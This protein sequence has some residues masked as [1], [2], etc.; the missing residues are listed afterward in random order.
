MLPTLLLNVTDWYPSLSS[1]NSVSINLILFFPFQSLFMESGGIIK[2]NQS[3]RFCLLLGIAK[4]AIYKTRKA[5][6]KGKNVNVL[7]CF[8]GMV[9]VRVKMEQAYLLSL[10]IVGDQWYTDEV[11]SFFS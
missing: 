6:L 5:R 4:L 8:E 11:L 2:V 1:F 10:D 3:S 9:S 7:L